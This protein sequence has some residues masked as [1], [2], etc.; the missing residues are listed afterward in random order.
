MKTKN[1][2]PAF[3][4]NNIPVIFATNESFAP[5]LEVCLKSLINNSSPKNNYDIVIFYT[6]LSKQIKNQLLKLNKQNVSIRL[7]DKDE[8]IGE[9]KNIWEERLSYTKE[10]YKKLMELRKNSAS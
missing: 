1:L 9:Y 8:Y 10:L 3:D 4:K 6:N 7:I 5:K 2:Y